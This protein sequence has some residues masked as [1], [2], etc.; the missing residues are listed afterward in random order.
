MGIIEQAVKEIEE[1]KD[2]R[3]AE[4]HKIAMKAI[5]ILVTAGFTEEN[6]NIAVNRIRECNGLISET[7]ALMQE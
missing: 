7:I 1:L 2:K 3:Q 5:V 4:E 6:I